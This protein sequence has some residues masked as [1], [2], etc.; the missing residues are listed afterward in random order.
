MALPPP[1]VAG[2]EC[3]ENALLL[4]SVKNQIDYLQQ[5]AFEKKE[6]RTTLVRI[7]FPP[8]RPRGGLNEPTATVEPTG[9]SGVRG[10]IR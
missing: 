7:V 1:F 8:D 5:S 10:E 9:P 4:L 2:C 3:L 6:K